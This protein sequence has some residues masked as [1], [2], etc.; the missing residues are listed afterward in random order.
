MTNAS[1]F[2]STAS[3]WRAAV[4]AAR[5]KHVVRRQAVGVASSNA[6]VCTARGTERREQ[7]RV[8]GDTC[9]KMASLIDIL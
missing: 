7:S 9:G 5:E 3:A 4:S 8:P 1:A 6:S 2:V